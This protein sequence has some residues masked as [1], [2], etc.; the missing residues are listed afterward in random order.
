M[1]DMS[2]MSL[3]GKD[4][5]NTTTEWLTI[6]EVVKELKRSTR[7]IERYVANGAL[8]TK[9]TGDDGRPTRLYHA[10]DVTRIATRGASNRCRKQTA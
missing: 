9:L 7:T 1:S 4:T 8:K 6:E 3:P 10:G 5:M 2:G